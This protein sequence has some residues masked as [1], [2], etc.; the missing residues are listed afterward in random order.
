MRKLLR[1][2]TPD[3]YKRPFTC[4]VTLE[5]NRVVKAAPVVWKLFMGKSEQDVRHH[6]R[7]RNWTVEE[8]PNADPIPEP[9]D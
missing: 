8:L 5:N 4:G 7:I 9:I 3:S 1:I 6:C 2:S